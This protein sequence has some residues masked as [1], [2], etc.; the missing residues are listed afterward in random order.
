M[1]DDE[2]KKFREQHKKNYKNALLDNIKNNTDV[3]VDQD[4]TSLLKKPPL[5]S[6]DMIKSKYLDLAKK[7]KIVLNTEILTS[8]VD[9]YHEFMLTCCDSIKKYR[10]K[11][12][13]S[14]V[15]NKE[16]KKDNETIKLLKKDFNT[17]NKEIRKIIK[18]KL[19]SGY[20]DILMKNTNKIFSDDVSDIVKTKIVDSIS[21][22]VKGA[23]QKQLFD[24]FEMKILVK[25]TT[26][27]NSCNEQNERYIF[28]LNNSRL[29]NDIK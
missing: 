5:D 11:E 8:M 4:I 29:L 27:I 1:N 14:K 9:E 26:L 22:Y 15:E 2:L 16:L 12:L 24:S 10:C 6:M 25:D 28:T 13:C 21:T 7:N 3:L 20:E 19:S 23:Y 17:I 18:D